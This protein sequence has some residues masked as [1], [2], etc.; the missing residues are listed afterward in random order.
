MPS[1]VT[2][3]H[4][5]LF[6][7]FIYISA[8]HATDGV[9]FN[10]DIKPILSDK[11]YACHGPDEGQRQGGGGDGLRFDIEANAKSDLGGYSAIAPGNTEE[12]EL[13]RRILS[14]DRSRVLE[15][16]IRCLSMSQFA[17]YHRLMSR[18]YGLLA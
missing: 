1:V 2:R 13:V 17:G 4:L 8:T 5:A 7:S 16:T 14:D 10:R 3:L 11:C 18:R 12:S 15:Q 6:C 9:N